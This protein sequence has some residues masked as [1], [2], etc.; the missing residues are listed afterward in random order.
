MNNLL[1]SLKTLGIDQ[2]QAQ[3]YLAC[4]ELG[5]ATIQELAEKSK[6]KRTSIYNFLEEIK[7]LGLVTEVKEGRKLLLVAENPEIVLKRAQRRLELVQAE[8]PEFLSIYNSPANK[9]KVRFYQGI[10]GLQKAYSDYAVQDGKIYAFTDFEKMFETLPED[11]LWAAGP[12]ARIKSNTFFY[13]IG[14]DGPRGRM[15]QSKD[16]EELR[17]TKL[18]KDI[19]FETEINIYSNKISLISFKKPYA[20]VIIEDQ[21]IAQTMKSIW[22]LVW[23]TLK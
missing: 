20:A 2:K 16:K 11:F 22:Q 19:K 12:K 7:D 21:A 8:L 14:K 4:L 1:K 9:P 10:D 13:S 17:Q 23:N 18:V 5:S 3:V 15:V 6:V